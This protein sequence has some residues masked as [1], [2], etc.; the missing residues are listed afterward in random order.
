M[1]DTPITEAVYLEP[2]ETAAIRPCRSSVPV[3]GASE[4]RVTRRDLPNGGVEWVC[5]GWVGDRRV[6]VATMRCDAERHAVTGSA[7]TEAP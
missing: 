7:G 1:P 4:V 2:G 6:T 3:D 5:E